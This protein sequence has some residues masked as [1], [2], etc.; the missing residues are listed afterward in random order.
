MTD[1]GFGGEERM[2]REGNQDGA[3]AQSDAAG[4]EADGTLEQPE[5][6]TKF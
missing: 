2:D 6:E 5:N 1:V 4:T 3:G